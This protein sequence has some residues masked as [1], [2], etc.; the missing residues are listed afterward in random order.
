MYESVGGGSLLPENLK[1]LFLR[2]G[3]VQTLSFSMQSRMLEAFD[4]ALEVSEYE[5]SVQS[6]D[7]L[8]TNDEQSVSGSATT[9]FSTD[10]ANDYTY[11]EY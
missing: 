6:T 2:N 7:E 3:N 11:T 1:N 8:P 9:E 10:Y 5:L 4:Y